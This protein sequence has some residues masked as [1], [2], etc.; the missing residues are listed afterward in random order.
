MCSAWKVF[1]FELRFLFGDF[2]VTGCP[3]K[4]APQFLLD[5]SDYKHP[6]RLRHILFER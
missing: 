1:E 4:N 5:I 3:E 2:T 6:R